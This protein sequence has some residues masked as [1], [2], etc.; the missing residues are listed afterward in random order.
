MARA[1]GHLDR[2]DRTMEG[3][4]L[5]VQTEVRVMGDPPVQV[6]LRATV[7]HRVPEAVLAL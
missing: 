3:H 2:M 5:P 4:H 1:R 7:A 6:G